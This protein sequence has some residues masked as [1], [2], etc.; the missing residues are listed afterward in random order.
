MG[1]SASAALLCVPTEE[2]VDAGWLGDGLIRGETI[3][4]CCDGIPTDEIVAK[5]GMILRE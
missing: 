1:G 4:R 3:H 5:D 2:A